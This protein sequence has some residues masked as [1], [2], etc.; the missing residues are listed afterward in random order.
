MFTPFASGAPLPPWAAPA[1]PRDLLCED[2]ASGMARVAELRG[3]LTIGPAG[4]GGGGGGG[5]TTR[6]QVLKLLLLLLEV[7]SGLGGGGSGAGAGAGAALGSACRG[8]A[9]QAHGA[10]AQQPLAG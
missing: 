9:P 4:G 2:G 1:W 5:S 6:R 10:G 8:A 7:G 3:Y